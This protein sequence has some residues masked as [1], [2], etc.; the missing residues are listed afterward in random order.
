RGRRFLLI[1]RCDATNDRLGRIVMK[2]LACVV[3]L[4]IVAGTSSL[5]ADIPLPVAPPSAAYTPVAL[6]YSYDWSGFYIGSNLGAG[7]N[8]TPS[9]T[10]TFGSR[11]ETTTTNAFLGGGQV[12][13]NYEVW[14]FFVIGAE[15]MF[16][17][18]PNTQ[19]TVSVTNTTITPGTT[20]SAAVTFNNRWV[21]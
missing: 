3:P 10:D 2:W 12:G 1:C 5:A 16:D 20:N 4:S 6:P 13:V 9:A 14:T 19:N 11:F 7:F 15:A 21:T 17:W 8:N 18:L